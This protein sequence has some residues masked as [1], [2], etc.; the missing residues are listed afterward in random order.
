MAETQNKDTNKEKKQLTAT[1]LV[2][3]LEYSLT[4]FVSWKSVTKNL[5]L[6][7][8]VLALYSY[9]F[10]DQINKMPL[11]KRAVQHTN[12]PLLFVS[13]IIFVSMIFGTAVAKLIYYWKHK[14]EGNLLYTSTEIFSESGNIKELQ[15]SQEPKEVN[16]LRLRFSSDSEYW[17]LAIVFRKDGKDILNYHLYKDEKDRAVHTR[18]VLS[19]EKGGK[20]D[21]RQFSVADSKEII[22]MGFDSK[23]QDIDLLVSG[24]NWARSVAKRHL[25]KDFLPDSI[26]VRAWGDGR[27]YCIAIHSLLINS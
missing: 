27:P 6:I 17:R 2:G 21:E 7:S 16:N 26:L 22:G 12:D 23:K 25:Q 14:G 9:F 13:I 10:A 3:S 15:V 4:D 19:N 1:T 24:E 11:F 18:V 20:T 5:C 8:L